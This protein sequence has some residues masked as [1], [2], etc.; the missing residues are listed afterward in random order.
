M[1]KED[2]LGASTSSIVRLTVQQRLALERGPVSVALS[3]GA[4][5]GKTTVLTER[6]LQELEGPQA[7]PLNSLL[8]LTF[9]EKAARE[10][11]QRIRLS[12]RERIASGT[13]PE[14]HQWRMTLRGLEAA[15]IG[16]FHE[17][18]ARMLRV[19]AIESGIDPEFTV[20]DESIGQALRDQAVNTTLSRAVS[21]QDLDII[22]LAVDYGLGQ[23]R[24]ALGDI[25]G[26][27][28]LEELRNWDAMDQEETLACWNEVWVRE[29]RSSLIRQAAH[30]ARE[31]RETLETLEPNSVK[32]RNRRAEILQLICDLDG[33]NP[34][35]D[36]LSE[37]KNLARISDLR[38]KDLWPSEECKKQVQK[39]FESLRKALEKILPRLTWNEKQ[40]REEIVNRQRLIRLAIKARSAYER[41]KSERN[42]LDFDDLQTRFV[43]LIRE[44]PELLVKSPSSPELGEAS[45]EFILVDEFQDTDRLQ[46]E[47][48]RRMGHTD[49]LRG[50]LFVVG[51]YRQ[52]I[53]GFRG[54]DPSI[55][56]EWRQ[57]FPPLG[58]RELSENFRSVPGIVHFVNA[59]FADSFGPEKESTGEDSSLSLSR[60]VPMRDA[61]SSEP[62][63]EFHWAE[64]AQSRSALEDESKAPPT[65][66]RASVK[67]LRRA[68]A[69]SLA[70]HIRQRLQ[71]GWTNPD[72]QT[73]VSRLARP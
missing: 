34:T 54:A 11:R 15:P 38:G 31:C 66:E 20:L 13:E 64:I 23:I 12:C 8:A 4:G 29:G 33:G 44:H 22:D 9:T 73:K 45:F 46:S 63:V 30:S 25:L 72:P 39:R 10:L 55:F 60:L 71:K 21:D 18:C 6:F 28:S 68:E 52:S 5:C 17:F 26:S 67:E 1:D 57:A 59:L 40:T 41:L 2:E 43:D 32:L 48:L 3:A 50:R 53:Y 56:Q 58:R 36:Q 49:F 14:I 35:F 47:I 24:D 61:V 27:A 7:R 16:T 19:H 69:K 70:R 37:L 51:D 42:G 65:T 62:A